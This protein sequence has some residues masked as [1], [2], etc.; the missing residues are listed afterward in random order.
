MQ[1]FTYLRN[2]LENDRSEK[3]RFRAWNAMLET[4]DPEVLNFVI[5]QAYRFGISGEIEDY[6]LLVAL[7]ISLNLKILINKLILKS[8]L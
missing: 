4:R 7:V 8:N 2:V 3:K 5:S 1:H 6:L